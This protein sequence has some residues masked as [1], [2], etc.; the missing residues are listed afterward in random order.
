MDHHLLERQSAAHGGKEIARKKPFHG[1]SSRPSTAFG[2]SPN[3][4]KLPLNKQAGHEIGVFFNGLRKKS[5]RADIESAFSV[6]GE[7]SFLR[8]PF[9]HRRN[10]NLGSGFVVFKDPKVAQRLL[11]E[12]KQVV[13]GGKPIELAL[14]SE[15]ET[16]YKKNKYMRFAPPSVKTGARDLPH[17]PISALQQSTAGSPSSKGAVQTLEHHPRFITGDLHCIKPSQ[18]RY[19][20]PPNIP[21]TQLA[22]FDHRSENLVFRLLKRAVYEAKEREPADAQLGSPDVLA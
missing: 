16:K 11:T 4:T 12:V 22:S 6:F 1:N 21:G 3:Q 7:I 20:R 15:K 2:S 19:F 17:K 9:N 8:L 10:R 14:Y 18:S 5:S 13:I